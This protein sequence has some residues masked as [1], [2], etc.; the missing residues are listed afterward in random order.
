YH[1]VDLL[2]KTYTCQRWRVYGFSCSHATTA[3]SA[4]V[5]RYVDYIQDYFKVTNFQQLYSIAIRPVPNYN[6]P[7]Q[8][9][10]EDTIFPPYPRVPP[11]R[12]KGNRIKNA[13]EK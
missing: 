9:E 11:G 13:W 1:T 8:Y 2:S 7:E 10:P 3:I 5:D 6:R 12:P 4:K